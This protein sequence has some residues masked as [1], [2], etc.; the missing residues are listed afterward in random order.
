MLLLLLVLSFGG[1]GVGADVFVPTGAGGF[2]GKNP[3]INASSGD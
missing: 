2:V 1:A 3:M